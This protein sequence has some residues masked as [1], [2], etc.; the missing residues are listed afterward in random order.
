MKLLEY[1]PIKYYV[2]ANRKIKWFNKR[3]LIEGRGQGRLFTK[4]FENGGDKSLHNKLKYLGI[5]IIK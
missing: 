5:S 1:N 3:V 2:C 4:V